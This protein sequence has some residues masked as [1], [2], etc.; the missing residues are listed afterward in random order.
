M[1]LVTLKEILK[2]SVE[3]K[4]AVGAFDTL[5][6]L[7]T[8]AI[9]RAAEEEGKPV[10]LMVIDHFFDQRSDHTVYYR[11]MI[12]MIEHMK[13]P[14]CLMLDHGESYEDCMRAIHLGFTAVM[15]DG[16]MLPYEDNVKLVQAV[17]R[18][19]HACGVSVEAEIGHVGGHETAADPEG[20]EVDVS[21]YTE[22]EMAERF[23]AETGV[24]A[25]A[26]AFGTVH[27]KYKGKVNLDY[28]RLADIRSRVG[29]PLVMHGGSG[30]PEDGFRGAVEHGINKINICTQMLVSASDAMNSMMTSSGG[31]AG[32]IDLYE[33]AHK[34]VR[35]VV[36]THMGIFGT[37]PLGY[38]RPPVYYG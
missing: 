14:V 24:D 31:K 13:T 20:S 4:Y 35:E 6:P 18:S 38:D 23:A 15:I 16:S 1:S 3:K 21:G 11:N 25:L 5:N 37:Q 2:G 9:L 29:I 32:F 7:M 36:K 30:I 12:N 34:A 28:A 22:P 19:A 26:I 27:G 8:E 33:E 10:I 17:V